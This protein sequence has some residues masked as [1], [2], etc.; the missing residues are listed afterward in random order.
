MLIQI[1]AKRFNYSESENYNAQ[2]GMQINDD[3]IKKLICVRL[4]GER[5]SIQLS[6]N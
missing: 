2:Q 5:K 4:F 6:N 1:P 3:S